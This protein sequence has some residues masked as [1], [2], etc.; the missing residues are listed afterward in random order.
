[1]AASADTVKSCPAVG[2]DR[3]LHAFAAGNPF[4]VI[5]QVA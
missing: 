5:R 4:R 1:M 2:E 3:Q